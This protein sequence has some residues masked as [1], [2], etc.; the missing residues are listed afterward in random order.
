M[1]FAPHVEQLEEWL[2]PITGEILLYGWFDRYQVKMLLLNGLLFFIPLLLVSKKA[3]IK[4]ALEFFLLLL[5]FKNTNIMVGFAVFFCFWHSRDALM[6]QLK[7]IKTTERQLNLT[8]FI[9]LLIPYSV[10]SITAIA[11]LVAI[12]FFVEMQISWVIIF[13]III[14]SLTL[15]HSFLI[16]RF[17]QRT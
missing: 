5:L 6:Y 16:T 17:Y 8:Q 9:R 4:E 2:T 10:I 15:P 1:L 3:L 7:G 11:I 14:A 13:F 12:S